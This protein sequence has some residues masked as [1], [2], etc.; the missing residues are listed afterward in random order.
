MTR[1]AILAALLALTLPTPDAGAQGQNGASDSARLALFADRFGGEQASPGGLPTF[2]KRT[3]QQPSSGGPALRAEAI[4]TGDLVRIGDLIDNAGA[5]A[6][7]AIFRAPD[8]G[9][10]G[11]VP[12]SSVIEAV[13]PHQIVGLDTRGIA[14]VVVTRASRMIGSKD[15]EA[16]IL[17]AIAGQYGA[18]EADRLA[19]TFD[20]EVR[21]FQVEPFANAELRVVRLA[22]EPKNGRFDVTFE[23]P[24]STVARKLPLRFTGS[25]AETFDAVVLVR[26]IAAGELIKASDLTVARRPKSEFAANVVTE[27]AQAVGRTSRRPLRPGQ[28]MR[29]SELVKPEVVARNDNVTITFS[30]PGIMLTARGQAVEPGAQGDVINVVNIQ[31]K[32][33]IRATVVGPGHVTVAGTAPIVAT[34]GSPN[35][36]R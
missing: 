30:V 34:A 11:S 31:S 23:L 32:K 24:G 28:S 14:E 21:T 27:T 19:V 18:A 25:I 17:R 35:S 1:I 20:N 3:S 10:T 5:A 26:P 12:A 29:Q 7:V 9:Q 22:Y 33:T 4:V 8:L 36:A 13:R 16:R 15:I 2:V 6:D